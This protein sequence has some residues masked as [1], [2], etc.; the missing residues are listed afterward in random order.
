MTVEMVVPKGQNRL[1]SMGG[2]ETN[3]QRWEDA[4]STGFAPFSFLADPPETPLPAKE[5][6]LSGR[7]G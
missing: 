6:A 1:P 2:S 3:S 7:K 5:L 4:K